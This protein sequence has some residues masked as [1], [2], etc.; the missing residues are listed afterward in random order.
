MVESVI[1]LFFVLIVFLFTIDLLQAMKAKILVEYAAAKC[2]RARAVGYNDF[3]LTKIARLATMPA[4]GKCKTRDEEGVVI[5]RGVATHKMGAYLNSGHE[6]QA[7]QILDFEFWDDTFV[8][9]L[10]DSSDIKVS[11]SQHRKLPFFDSVFKLIGMENDPDSRTPFELQINGTSKI[12]THYL[13]YLS[14]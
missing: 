1:A 13:D 9:T 4:A 3:M 10:S 2:A 11:V 5:S 7:D 6:A 8:S 12:G 14:P